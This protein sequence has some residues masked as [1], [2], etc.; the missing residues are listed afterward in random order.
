MVITQVDAIGNNI[1]IET[2]KT[3]K[4]DNKIERY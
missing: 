3:G 4:T 2:V 1:R